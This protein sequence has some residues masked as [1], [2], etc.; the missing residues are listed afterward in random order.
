MFEELA[1]TELQFSEDGSMRV[2]PPTSKEDHTHFGLLTEPVVVFHAL[3]SSSEQPHQL[4]R[5]LCDLRPHYVVMYDP[6]VRSVRQLEVYQ[7]SHPSAS[8]R[9][10]F[11]L[12]D[13]SVEEQKYLTALRRE[14]EAFQQLIKDRAHM[15]LP[16]DQ[17]G[18]A[19]NTLDHTQS[20]RAGGQKAVEKVIVDVREFRSSLPSLLHKRG[21]EILP[22]T[23]EVGD[24]VLSPDVCVE[25]KSVSD[26]IGSL[27]SGRL[28]TQ[29]TALTRHYHRPV[30]LIEFPENKAFSLKSLSSLQ[31]DISSQSTLSKLVLLTLHFP[32]LRIL[33]CSSPHATADLFLQIK[34]GQ[35]QPDP[36]QAVAVGQDSLLSTQRSE[37]NAAAQDFLLKLPGVNSKNYRYVLDGVRDFQE[38][39]SLSQTQLEQLL[40]NSSNASLLFSFL[41]SSH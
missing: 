27:N 3:D 8:L 36:S 18:G 33:W 40:G 15:V 41:H 32:R 21:M 29:A 14:K 13:S 37:Y 4:F 19:T 35:A 6:D 25:R 20:R 5:V 39:V 24:Y 22:L 23:L 34:C 38:L 7:A 28:Y 16:V 1:Q 2:A 11:L 12:Y 9:V 30:L 10:Y 31:S 26:L 17:E